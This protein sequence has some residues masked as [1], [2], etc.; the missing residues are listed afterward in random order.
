MWSGVEHRPERPGPGL[1]AA[2]WEAAGADPAGRDRTAASCEDLLEP[3]LSGCALGL[4]AWA[5]RELGSLAVSPT[6]THSSGCT[7]ARSGE[8][9][10]HLYIHI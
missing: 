2:G 5:G 10:V 6:Q 7:Y 1:W 4:V 3:R 9:G 8:G